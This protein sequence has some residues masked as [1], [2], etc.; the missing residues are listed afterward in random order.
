ME[1]KR[2]T[3]AEDLGRPA[4]SLAMTRVLKK[5]SP[6]SV[7]GWTLAVFGTFSGAATFVE[8]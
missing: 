4:R 8:S 1:R 2:S 5:Q 3:A 6:R 7:G